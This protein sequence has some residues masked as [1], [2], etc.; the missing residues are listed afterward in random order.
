[1]R[2]DF[3]I[4]TGGVLRPASNPTLDRWSKWKDGTLV[5]VT[6][7]RPRHANRL[8][9]YWALCSRIADAL[10]NVTAENVSDILKI[11]T[12]HC[13]IIKG[14]TDTWRV[15]QSISFTQMSEDQFKEFLAR[16]VQIIAE[17]WLPALP[18]SEGRAAVENILFEEGSPQ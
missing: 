5:Q 17:Q 14:K 6:V 16:A 3:A 4:V 18:P 7:N 9:L 10:G 13:K 2:P 1:M 8:R 15:P 12:G 11:E